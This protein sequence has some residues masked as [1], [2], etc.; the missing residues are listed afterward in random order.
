MDIAI[1]KDCLGVTTN[2]LPSQRQYLLGS[3]MSVR[4]CRILCRSSIIPPHRLHSRTQAAFTYVHQAEILIPKGRM[5]L[6]I[7]IQAQH[8]HV[9]VILNLLRC[10][11][12][13]SGTKVNK[14]GLVP[15]KHLRMDKVEFWRGGLSAASWQN[16]KSNLILRYY[17]ARQNTRCKTSTW[18]RA[19]RS[20]LSLPYALFTLKP[21]IC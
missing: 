10:S 18:P 19:V 5:E 17:E 13:P 11:K 16:L 12:V 3:R 8:T 21:L 14:D 6:Q 4:C 7:L 2:P 15:A 1:V 9:Q 20:S